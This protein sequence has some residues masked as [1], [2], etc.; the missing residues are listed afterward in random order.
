MNFVVKFLLN[1]FELAV[2]L[3]LCIPG[4]SSEARFRSLQVVREVG[5]RFSSHLVEGSVIKEVFYHELEKRK[6]LY[7]SLREVDTVCNDPSF[8]LLLQRIWENG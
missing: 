2:F 1:F 8:D 5:E 4:S 3:I 6:R 7:L